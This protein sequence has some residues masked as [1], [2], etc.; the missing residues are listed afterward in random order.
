MEKCRAIIH[1][2]RPTRLPSKLHCTFRDAPEYR[3]LLQ[4]L[5]CQAQPR[6]FVPLALALRPR[7][8]RLA[9]V[10]S[11]GMSSARC[12]HPHFRQWGV[13]PRPQQLTSHPPPGKRHLHSLPLS[14]L[15]HAFAH[16]CSESLTEA[17]IKG[18][19]QG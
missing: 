10:H 11:R 16:A 6:P 9:L 5:C 19:A 2:P 3:E 15:A 18:L 14:P 12:S 1:Y 4:R 7:Q 8:R 17:H 13:G